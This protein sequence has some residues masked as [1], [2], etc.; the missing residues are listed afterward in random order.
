MK[1]TKRAISLILA[2]ILLF[3]VFTGCG[4]TRSDRVRIAIQPSAA[5]IPLFV[6][7]EKGW[8]EQALREYGVSVIWNTFESGPPMNDSL[9]AGDSDVGVIGDVPTVTVCAP[10]NGVGVVAVAAQAAD[11]YAVLVSADSDIETAS[12]LKGKRIAVTFGS[13]AHNMIEKYLISDNVSI[14]DV[15]LIN[16]AA[17]DAVTVLS[18]GQAEAVST[19][20][21][22]VTRLIAD[23]NTRVISVGSQVGLDG[24]NCIVVRKK[25]AK[26]NPEVVTAILAQYK[27]AA[28][29]LPGLDNET[30]EA[31]AKALNL[32]SDQ[33]RSI[34]PKFRYTVEITQEDIDALNDTIRFLNANKIMRSKYSISD[35]IDKSFYKGN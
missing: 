19:W 18:K 1:T 8:I 14:D 24:T 27:R 30:I 34:L 3:S 28:D 11:S 29:A 5:F 10:R 31:V 13:T 25:Y 6:A 33:L 20:E 35:S 15:S 16:I 23:G 17:G 22:N 32:T 7:K 9:L 26:A 4:G 2:I 12:D 21:P